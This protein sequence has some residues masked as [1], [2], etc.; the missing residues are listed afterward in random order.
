MLATEELVVDGINCG[1]VITQVRADAVR[2]QKWQND[3][4]HNLGRYKGLR[5]SLGAGFMQEAKKKAKSELSKL[6]SRKTKSPED[7]ERIKELKASRPPLDLI[8]ESVQFITP[9][10]FRAS[11]Q[12]RKYARE[13][14]AHA[15]LMS[16][17]GDDEEKIE[18]VN[19]AYL[20]FK[21][22]VLCNDKRRG[23]EIARM[24]AARFV[25]QERTYCVL[26]TLR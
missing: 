2:R 14:N 16:G 20:S 10:V 11:M 6:K 18:V 19:D 12:K 26:G 3:L 5:T 15:I 24:E 23:G 22:K 8:E 25:D 9:D 4:V 7:R 17:E 13:R 21:N 1:P